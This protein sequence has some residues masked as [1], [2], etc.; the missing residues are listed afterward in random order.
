M[1]ARKSEARIALD[2]SFPGYARLCPFHSHPGT[3]LFTSIALDR[4]LSRQAVLSVS[5]T[6]LVL[7]RMVEAMLYQNGLP[8]GRMQMDISKAG[9]L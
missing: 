9:H 6:Q 4:P 1:L 5:R 8:A 2:I 3:W 7:S